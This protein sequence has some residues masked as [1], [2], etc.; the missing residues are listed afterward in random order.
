MAGDRSGQQLAQRRQVGERPLV[1][2]ATA[3]HE[4]GAEV[5]KMRN[6]AAE[7]RQPEALEDEQHWKAE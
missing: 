7:G 6:R 3:N 4:F 2:P 5:A 1:H